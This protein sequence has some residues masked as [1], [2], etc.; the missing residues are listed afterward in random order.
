MTSNLLES[1]VNPNQCAMLSQNMQELLGTKGEFRESVMGANKLIE[2]QG[3][4]PSSLQEVTS[5]L[6][7][8]M[9]RQL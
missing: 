3:Q 2:L 4:L 8:D 1:V 5:S 7:G 9:I 6:R